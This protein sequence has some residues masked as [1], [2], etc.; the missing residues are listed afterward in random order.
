MTRKSLF[1]V[2]FLEAAFKGLESARIQDGLGKGVFSATTFDPSKCR[3]EVTRGESQENI[4]NYSLVWVRDTLKCSAFDWIAGNHSRLNETF[5]TL[6]KYFK[7]NLDLIDKTIKDDKEGEKLKFD[8]HGIMP[9]MHPLTLEPVH[10]DQ[11]KDLQLDMAEVLKYFVLLNQSDVWHPE[12]SNELLLIEKLVQYFQSWDYSLNADI[13]GDFGIWEEGKQGTLGAVIPDVHSSTIAIMLSGFIYLKDYQMQA[14]DGSSKIM[15]VDESEISRGFD[16]LNK[17]LETVGE[18]EER[19][20]DLTGLIILYE[21]LLLKESGRGELLTPENADK[22]LREF[23]KL[24]REKGF[25]RYASSQNPDSLDAYHRSQSPLG[26]SAEWTMGF[27]YAALIFLK[28]GLRDEAIKYIE[29]MESAFDWTVGL[30]LPEAYYGGT[31]KPVE[32][33]PLSWSNALYLMTYE[34]MRQFEKIQ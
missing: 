34:S 26:K 1:G 32:V 19:T 6:L 20:Y 33:S 29:K 3:T 31:N 5:N 11:R 15:R 21:H 24:E 25:V 18:T 2:R 17:R 7:H 23:N 13:P 22:I 12:D 28:L 14:S 4:D 16:L 8:V 30:G 10:A 27:G 9:R